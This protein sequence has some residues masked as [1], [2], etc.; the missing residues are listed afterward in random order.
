[1]RE[2]ATLNQCF[3]LDFLDT[4]NFGHDFGD[5]GESKNSRTWVLFSIWKIGYQVSQFFKSK[6]DLRDMIGFLKSYCLN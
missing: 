4:I 6:H 5:E 3:R 1:M 2:P